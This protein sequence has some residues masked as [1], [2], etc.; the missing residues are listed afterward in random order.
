MR[1]EQI[2]HS[3]LEVSVE[4][5]SFD[6]LR[7]EKFEYEEEPVSKYYQS[8]VPSK[9][10]LYFYEGGN[11][12]QVKAKY[13]KGFTDI[14]GQERQWYEQFFFCLGDEENPEIIEGLVRIEFFGWK[15]K[16]D[17]EGNEVNIFQEYRPPIVRTLIIKK[18]SKKDDQL[19]R[20][21][22]KK[23][24]SKM[25]DFAENLG[26]KY[27]RLVIEARH[28]TQFGLDR[29]KWDKI[30]KH[31]LEKKGFVQYAEGH[32][33]KVLDSSGQAQHN[34]DFEQYSYEV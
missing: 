9:S 29:Q 8:A 30:F 20:G 7:F 4:Q 33:F 13:N 10:N 32:W 1:D 5:L 17:L 25:L 15:S 26:Q 22:G 12:Y 2:H 14:E 24:S 19:Y 16:E 3:G 18:F 28:E 23:L 6:D 31:D 27:E 34:I 11:K 21:F